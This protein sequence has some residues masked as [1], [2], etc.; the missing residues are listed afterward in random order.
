MSPD[1]ARPL[2][3]VVID[4]GIDAMHPGVRGRG[5]VVAGPSFSAAGPDDPHGGARDH[6]G[7]GTAVAAVILHCVQPVELVALRIFD[8]DAT[9]AFD[10]V[11]HA[12][13]HAV[14]L[15]P[16][17]I[18][19]SLGTTSLRHRAALHEV[20]TL[21]KNRGVRITAPASYGGLACDPGSLPGVEAVVGDPNVLPML[22]ELR[23][24]GG[25]LL[26][27]ASPLPPPDADGVRRLLA[28]GDSLAVAAVTGCLLRQLRR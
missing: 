3:A 13:R 22:P 26:W 8:R 27:F 23:P 12:L 9:C 25:R 7:H 17:V 14:E 21:A 11:L 5:T 28:R 24:H 4:S 20:L 19:L 16:H 2:R 18:N 10:A 1:P 15:G 6:L